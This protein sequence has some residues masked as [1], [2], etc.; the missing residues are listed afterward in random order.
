MFS[1]SVL[2]SVS[3]LARKDSSTDAIAGQELA[4][5]LSLACIRIVHVAGNNIYRVY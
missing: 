2:G 4:L 5:G 1:T 3:R